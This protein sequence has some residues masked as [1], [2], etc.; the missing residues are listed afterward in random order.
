MKVYSSNLF[1]SY[2]IPQTIKHQ[3]FTNGVFDVFHAGH[4]S[5]L[6]QCREIAQQENLKVIVGVNSD[7]S[8]K[9]L[10]GDKRPIIPEFERVEILRGIS[11]IDYVIVFDNQSVFP[12]IEQIIPKIL[13]KGSDYNPTTS[14]KEIVGQEF[15]ET[16]GGE[17]RTTTHLYDV[18]TSTI[19]ERIKNV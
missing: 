10:K 16:R 13:V 4:M 1:E 9:Q 3:L 7:Y 6:K 8:V 12:T 19:I 5:L 2:G 15:V 14:E 17:I 18:S 11:Y